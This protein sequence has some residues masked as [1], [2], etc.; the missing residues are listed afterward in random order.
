[1]FKMAV[2]LTTGVI[3]YPIR[4]KMASSHLSTRPIKLVVGGA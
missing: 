2:V 1:M 3:R 4:A